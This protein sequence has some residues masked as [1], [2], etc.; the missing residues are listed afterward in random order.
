M[1][2]EREMTNWQARDQ[3]LGIGVVLAMLAPR[4]RDSGDICNE[5]V[6]IVVQS[7]GFGV[8]NRGCSELLLV[9]SAG[10]CVTVFTV[11]FGRSVVDDF[12]SIRA[13]V[14]VIS[15]LTACL[16][17]WHLDHR[18]HE[19]PDKQT[20]DGQRD[21]FNHVVCAVRSGP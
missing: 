17:P 8:E 3:R 4:L 21:P 11:P 12:A 14:S 10:I 18:H 6:E 2:N 13:S 9:L 20:D 16:C 15:S 7:F 5:A 19:S 1:R